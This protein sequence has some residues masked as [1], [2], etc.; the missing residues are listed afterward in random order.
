MENSKVVN[1]YARALFSNAL[2]CGKVEE[3][4]SQ[5]KVL[6]GAID[7][8]RFV[9]EGISSPIIAPIRKVEMLSKVMGQL[10]LHDLTKQFLL[11]MVKNSRIEFLDKV[12]DCYQGLLDEN[13][14][15]KVVHVTSARPLDKKDQDFIKDY[16]SKEISQKI[17]LKLEEDKKI[18]RGIVIRYDSKVIDCSI[19]GAIKKIEQ[20][21]A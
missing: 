14:S 17:E 3:V 10:A 15:V 7:R 21:H 8:D 2:S 19:L 18:I 1:N 5:I 12:I 11:T 4:L 16:L 6:G 9:K 13:N 20:T